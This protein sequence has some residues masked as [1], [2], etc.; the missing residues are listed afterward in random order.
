MVVLT[1]FGWVGLGLVLDHDAGA[2]RQR[3]IGLVTWAVVAALL[4]G[5]S[6]A[7]RAQ[8]LLVIVAATCV[9]Y[10][11]SVGL[12]L[13]TYRLGNVPLFVPPGHGL[14][15]LSA[16]A[17]GRS[18]AFADWRRLIVPATLVVAGSWALVGLAGPRHDVLG[19]VLFLFLVRFC[20]AGRAPLVYCGAFLL[21][22]YLELLGTG[23]GSWTWARHDPSGLVG[24]GNPPSVISGAYCFLD[25]FGLAAAPRLLAGVSGLLDRRHR[26]PEADE[27]LVVELGPLLAA[28]PDDRTTAPVD[29]VGV[30]QP[31]L[32][33]DL[34]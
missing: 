3:A 30:S 34:G 20:L 22:S 19:A 29:P 27:P 2:W 17:M 15:Y 28:G 1:G 33:S 4:A 12:G 11:A 24:M 7:L 13:Y 31:L 18:K 10:A 6:R 23:L 25:L 26:Q 14:V 32:V 8:V 21:T 5:E 16:I 9:E